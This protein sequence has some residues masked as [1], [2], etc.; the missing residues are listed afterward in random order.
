MVSGITLFDDFVFD[1]L[2]AAR[3]AREVG[4]RFAIGALHEL[5]QARFDQVALAFVEIDAAEVHHQTADGVDVAGGQHR[6]APGRTAWLM[7]S[8]I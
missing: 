2:F 5:A 3:F 7:V 1:R 4:V 6:T 8:A